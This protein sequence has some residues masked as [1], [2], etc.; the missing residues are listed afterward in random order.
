MDKKKLSKLVARAQRQNQRLNGIL[1]KMSEEI[2]R[3]GL[4]AD[5]IPKTVSTS[6][7]TGGDSTSEFDCANTN[8]VVN[9]GQPVECDSQQ[10][11]ISLQ[12]VDENGDRSAATSFQGLRVDIGDGN[13]PVDVTFVSSDGPT[14]NYSWDIP[15]TSSTDPVTA[16]FT[17]GDP[18]DLCTFSQTILPCE[19]PGAGAGAGSGAGTGSGG[20]TGGGG[21]DADGNV[22]PLQRQYPGYGGEA[23][24]DSLINN[25]YFMTNLNLSG[26]GSLFAAPSGS[27][28]VPLVAGEIQ[29][30][31]YSVLSTPNL[32]FLGQLAPGRVSMD[33][34]TTQN[35][36]PTLELT[37][38]NCL[39][40]YITFKSG[41][42]SSPNQNSHRPFSVEGGAKGVV[43]SHVSAH[44]G[45]D[46]SASIW[47]PGTENI[48]FYRSLFAYGADRVAFNSNPDYGNTIGGGSQR[49]SLFQNAYIADGRTPLFQ[50]TI[51]QAENNITYTNSGVTNLLQVSSAA[52]GISTAQYN[53]QNNLD[54]QSTNGASSVWLGQRNTTGT[55]THTMLAYLQNNNYRTC[56]N[57]N[58]YVPMGTQTSSS[59][60]DAGAD[61][62]ELITSTPFSMPT[63]PSITDMAELEAAL[64]PV[65]GNSCVRDAIDQAA[66]SLI[67]SCSTKPNQIT[68]S[69]YFTDPWPA[70]PTKPPLTI[71]DQSSPD[72]LT[73]AAKAA[74]GIAAGTNLLSPNNGRWEAVVDFH[75]NGLLSASVN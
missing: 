28:I 72:G 20:T 47:D 5:P 60:N 46:D 61:V 57:P 4:A 25:V 51:G 12:W 39:W 67:Q 13:G 21:H 75:T 23:L 48:T 1:E 37:G 66:I 34:D 18:N 35:N 63:L 38:S 22:V 7:V 73:D 50:N 14:N 11:P 33:G 6:G 70:G 31:A 44:Y 68:A 42:D 43:M 8:P 52:A 69:N 56:A 9:N 64:L 74:C 29:K 24:N 49:I 32:R 55:T 62:S 58:T 41:D 54:I 15:F 45:N 17:F 2:N 16:V 36:G 26:P 59:F 10:I 3:A 40:E 53:Y 71:W 27:Y 65:V 30:P 19:Q